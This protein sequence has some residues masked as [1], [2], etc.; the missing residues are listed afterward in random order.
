MSLGNIDKAVKPLSLR[1]GRIG[2]HIASGIF[3]T[4]AM[5]DVVEISQTFTDSC[6][7]IYW[8]DVC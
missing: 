7:W 6:D 2:F 1:F 8:D 3:F 5:K 4:L